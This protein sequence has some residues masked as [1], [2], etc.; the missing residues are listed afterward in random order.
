M[1]GKLL[2]SLVEPAKHF[3]RHRAAL[4]GAQQSKHDL[5]GGAL[6]AVTAVPALRRS[7][8]Q[9]RRGRLPAGSASAHPLL[10]D[11]V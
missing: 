1:I 6:L 4:G 2:G 8:G 7:G 11:R 9:S 5:Q 10:I 3:N